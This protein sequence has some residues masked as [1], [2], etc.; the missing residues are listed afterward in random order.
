MKKITS[1][2]LFALP[3]LI[4]GS[5]SL[6]NLDLDE[7]LNNLARYV[8]IWSFFLFILSILAIKLSNLKYKIWLTVSILVSILSIVAVY[9]DGDGGSYGI[10]FDGEYM[11]MWFASLYSI[12]S[13]IYF[14]ADF[15]INR[16][17][18]NLNKNK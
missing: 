9:P 14:V 15:F 2:V 4:L 1:L 13:V 8:L 3:V 5:I 10:G 16:K 12:V 11:T 6:F 7:D 18:L 17:R